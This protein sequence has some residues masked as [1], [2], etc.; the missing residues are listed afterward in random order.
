[1]ILALANT[2]YRKATA[3]SVNFKVSHYHTVQDLHKDIMHNN[4]IN[5]IKDFYALKIFTFRIRQYHDQYYAVTS[6]GRSSHTP[7][8]IVF[9]LTDLRLVVIILNT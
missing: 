3:T 1:M 2:C 7:L 6:F 5:F 8:L 9:G 4:A